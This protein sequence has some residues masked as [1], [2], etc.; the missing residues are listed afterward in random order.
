MPPVVV[1]YWVVTVVGTPLALYLSRYSDVFFYAAGFCALWAVLGFYDMFASPSNLRRNYPVAAY[2]R[3]LL[4]YIRPEMRQYFI[5]S[6]TDERPFNR[7]ARNLVYRR[8]KDVPDTLPFGTEQDLFSDGYLSI[9]HSLDPKIVPEERARVRIGGPQCDRPYD[10]SR[11]N[12]SAMSYGA[13]GA[14]AIRALNRGAKRGGFAHNTGEGGLSPYHLE[15]GGDIVWQI[16]TGYFGCRDDDGGFDAD[17]FAARA[18]LDAVKMIEIKLS[19]GAKP[20][21]GGVLPAAKVTREIAAIR[22]VEPG[23]DVISPPAHSAFEGPRGL[24]E[25]VARLRAL[26]GGKPTGFKLCLGRRA[27]FMAICKAMLETGIRPD[28]ITI[29]GAE[30]GTGAAPV[31]FSNRLGTPCIEALYYVDQVLTGLNLRND[32]RLIA[33]GKTATGF[34]M[35]VKIA[36]GADA[37]NAARTMMMALGCIQSQRCDTNHCPTGIATQNRR[38]GRAVDIADK[39]RRVANF[40][41]NTIESFL[42]LCGAMGHDD[43]EDLSAAEIFLRQDRQARNFDEIY[44]PLH[45]GQLLGEDIP[46]AYAADW[47]TAVADRF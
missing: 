11:L 13:L 14:N 44:A 32:I 7:E 4:E 45:P 6:N 42:E 38:R 30:G 12:I 21:H 8:A 23:R 36:L 15:F 3:Y 24:L 35:L 28:F 43:P 31:E 46:S 29:D 33:S 41:R 22:L 16:G 20:S 19:Q 2:L 39:H 34:D 10:A 9:V 37:V 25:F 40:H 1:I 18:T 47:R 17:A 26:S 27:E 5:A